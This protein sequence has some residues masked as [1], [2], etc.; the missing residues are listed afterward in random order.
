MRRLAWL[1][2]PLVAVSGACGGG[3]HV[4]GQDGGIDVAADAPRSDATGQTDGQSDAGGGDALPPPPGF[5][6]DPTLVPRV[7]AIAGIGTGPMRT[8]ATL[9]DAKGNRADFVENEL[10]VSTD[11]E[12]KVSAFLARWNGTVLNTIDFAQHGLPGAPK[13]RIVQVSA[14]AAD[15]SRIGEDIRV[16]DGNSRG[17]H[18]ISSDAGLHLLAAGA[19]EAAGGLPVSLNWVVEGATVASGSTAED[20]MGPA[21]YTPDAFSWPYV[22]RGSAQDIGVGAAW[23]ALVAAGKVGNR[24]K[25][26]VSDG[27]FY[28]NG[29]F[30]AGAV[31]HGAAGW[32]IPNPISCGGDP[33]PWHG[34]EV[35]SAAMGALDNGFGGAGPAGQIGDLIAVQSPSFD[36]GQIVS[37]IGGAFDALTSGPR[38]INM[39]WGMDVPAAAGLFLD[40]IINLLTGILHDAGVLMF[41]SAGNWDSD[42]HAHDVDDKDC[43]LDLCWEDTSWVPCENDHVIC[44]G[45]MQKDSTALDARSNWGTATDEHTVDIYAPMEIYVP[46][47]QDYGLPAGRNWSAPGTSFSS[48]FVAGV[49]AMVWAADPTLSADDVWNKVQSTAHTGGLGAP[50]PFSAKRVDAFSAVRSALGGDVPP[51]VAIDLPAAG[52]TF[53]WRNPAGFRAVTYDLDTAGTP[54]VTWSSDRDGVLG[55]GLT[56]NTSALSVG[57]HHITASALSGGKTSTASV[58]VKVVNDI[59]GVT[60]TEPA[61]SSSFCTTD[62]ISFTAVVSDFNNPSTAPFPAS[63]VAW[64]WLGTTSGT[65]G[66]G[67]HLTKVFPAGSYVVTAKATDEMGAIGMAMTS[68]AVSACTNTPPTV[69]ITSP[70]AG[71]GSGPDLTVSATVTDSTGEYAMVTLTGTATDPEDGALTGAKLVWTTSRTDVQAAMLGTGGSVSVKLYVSNPTKCFGTVDHVITLTATDSGGASRSVSRVIRVAGLC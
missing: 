4:N 63:G 59:P 53:H 60:I 45:G 64:T 67:F 50:G 70:P 54:T 41:A 23:Q 62:N 32:G 48:P 21:G 6:V 49:A 3:G 30:P 37:F 24:V 39:S 52:M 40:G 42:F 7:P 71:S 58:D 55:T 14:A 17:T 16:V 66:T 28:P 12:A 22:T 44:V 25:M 13:L 19:H 43:I 69:S 27:G 34:T 26:I 8:L 29:D 15:T 1:A 56:F 38:I 33:C 47:L 36:I 10:L 11:D 68:F 9:S 51:Y 46:Y 18:T 57:M 35:V 5:T 61:V 31:I 65:I 20:P 2:F